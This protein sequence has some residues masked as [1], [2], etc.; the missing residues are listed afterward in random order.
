MT[1]YAYQAVD[2]AGQPM[3]GTLA[4]TNQN[5]ALRRIR[6]MGLFPL[7]LTERR[8]ERSLPASPTPA[9]TRSRTIASLSRISIP[10]LQGRVKPRTLAVFTRQL[11]T[12]IDAG[13]PLLRGLRILQQQE[14][15][16][17]LKRIV[18]QV[19][20][21]IEGGGS[22]TE[23]LAAHPKDF[24]GLYVN[25]VRAGEI[26]GTLETT[27]RRLAEFM[28]KAQKIKGKVKAAMFYPAAVMVV[29]MAILAVMMVFVVPRFQAVFDGLL[30]GAAM[31]AFTRF[32]M[33]LSDVARHNAPM[34]GLG[35][36]VAVI[37]AALALRT[38]WGRW[39]F[40]LLKLRAPVIG[41]VFRKTGISR[42]TRTLG[43]L[44]HS[45]VPVLQ[46]L[47]IVKETAGNKIVGQLVGDIHESVKQGETVTA[48]L[49]N[50]SV[51]SPV[52]VGMVD[53][54][55]QTGALPDMLLKIAD[56]CDDDVD[57]AVNAMTSLLEPI[58][59]VFLAVIVGS[60]VIAMFLP[61]IT[62]MNG[63]PIGGGA[64]DS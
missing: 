15:N 20:E 39:T 11:A 29:A 3:R 23:A 30:G 13:M 24:N 4:V 59:I 8:P 14:T 50:S 9:E 42:L 35:I 53:V 31:P 34:M 17:R 64:G 55:E 18:G 57:N 37:A 40:D 27:L 48:P 2:S 21:T 60:I 62:I 26:S 22:L 52:Y 32:V 63:D 45:G 61:L 51:F 12:L 41:P 25:M 19:A 1:S 38:Q 5:E 54:G 46:A 43:T 58:L 16:P 28:E 33:G 49:R 36:L 7:K 56:Q 44:L 6:E 47:T 10:L